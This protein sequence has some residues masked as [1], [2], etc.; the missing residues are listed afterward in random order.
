MVCRTAMTTPSVFNMSSSST[1]SS[2][3]C[4]F[5]GDGESVC[6]ILA[7]R[8]SENVCPI[9]TSRNSESVCPILTSRYSESVCPI[10]AIR[11]VQS[12]G[13]Q[14]RLD[15]KAALCLNIT[16][17][18]SSAK[19]VILVVKLPTRVQ[20]LVELII[21]LICMGIALDQEI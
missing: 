11:S 7:S 16:R 3:R 1:L 8:D 20:H 10:L 19:Q 5:S 13:S 9:H 14:L 2:S 6:P 15:T 17:I 21:L 12:G 4:V 18:T